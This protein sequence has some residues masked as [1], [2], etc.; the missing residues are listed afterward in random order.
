M[1]NIITINLDNNCTCDCI[2]I[3]DSKQNSIELEFYCSSFNEPV[4]HV[5]TPDGVTTEHSGVI[6]NVSHIVRHSLENWNVD[7]QLVVWVT[8]GNFTSENITFICTSIAENQNVR[9]QKD[10]D[11][12]VIYAVET[13]KVPYVPSFIKVYRT[14]DVTNLSTSYNYFD[15]LTG[16][17]GHAVDFQQGNLSQVSQTVTTFGDRSNYAVQGVRIGKNINK[18]RVTA[19]VSHA[20]QT[21]YYFFMKTLICMVRDDTV[22]GVASNGQRMYEE[23]QMIHNLST[24][25]EVTEGDFICLMGYKGVASRNVHVQ[26]SVNSHPKMT[27]LCVEAIG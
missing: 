13:S 14:T 17:N 3:V 11:T 23:E 1:K 26:A 18:V 4:I 27:H 22:I 2:G 24:I 5:T 9:V 6:E 19:N 12:Y 7:G 10:G 16:A 8:D 20:N 21:S 25:I 15:P